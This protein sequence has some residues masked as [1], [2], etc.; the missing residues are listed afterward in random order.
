[1]V[2]WQNDEILIL[3]QGEK[4]EILLLMQELEEQGVFKHFCD[5]NAGFMGGGGDVDHLKNVIGPEIAA[6]F[7]EEGADI[8][9]MT[10]G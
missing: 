6:M 8:I 5:M 2:R 9:L 7:K 10:A 4:N 3:I 1:M